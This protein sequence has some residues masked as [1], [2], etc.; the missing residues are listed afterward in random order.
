[1]ELTNI[2][3]I[4]AVLSANGFTF[5]KS[6]GQ[7]FLTAA[8]VPERIADE[9]GA[10]A[11]V[12]ALEIGPGIGCLTEKLCERAERVIAVELDKRLI[13]VLA[14]TLAGRD[15]LTVIN[16]DVMALDLNSLDF[17]GLR[18][19]VAAN[20]P[21]NI[22]SPVITKLLGS[23]LFSSVTVMVQRE[24]A[25]RICAEP[26]TADYGAFTL[27][28][29]YKAEC[30]KLFNVP[31][32][33]F[34]PRPK[35]ESAVVRMDMREK[36][37]VSIDEKALFRVIRAAFNQRRK[38]LANALSSGISELDKEKIKA[39]IEKAGLSP[40]ARG[41]ELSLEKFAALTQSLFD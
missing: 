13:P 30:R 15:N 38:T 20:L 24:V 7:N 39:A 36:P 10:G 33:C 3:D 21:Y 32:S 23:G 35:V 34:E 17:A 11:G 4:R 29:R 12:C 28:C 8:W 31:S 1:M 9:C 40:T 26:K 19:I 18:P 27:F 5:S 2:N 6:M 22:T 14:Q 16:A 41:E 25:D 37:P